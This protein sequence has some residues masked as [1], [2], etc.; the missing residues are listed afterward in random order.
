MGQAPRGDCS[1]PGTIPFPDAEPVP[2]TE[3]RRTG[4]AA[5]VTGVKGLLPG[6]G[7]CLGRGGPLTL[8]CES[9]LGALS[10]EAGPQPASPARSIRFRSI[11]RHDCDGDMPLDLSGVAVRPDRERPARGCRG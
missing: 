7:P 2:L 6:D 4:L 10:D 1:L 8:E 9:R 5:W 11:A 3:A